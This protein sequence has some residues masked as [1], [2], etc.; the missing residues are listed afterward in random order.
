MRHAV[1]AAGFVLALAAAGPA[2]AQIAGRHDYGDVAAPAPFIGDS[3]LR[4]PSTAREM[5]ALRDRIDDARDSGRISPREARRLDRET[6][7]IGLAARRYGR[8][9]LSAAESRELQQ[10]ALILRGLISAPRPKREPGRR[11]RG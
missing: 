7:R 10:R 6:R 2:G 3:S 8:D 4:G 1:F 11:G 9:G 5:R